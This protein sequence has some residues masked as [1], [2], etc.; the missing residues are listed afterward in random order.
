MYPSGEVKYAKEIRY[1][2]FVGLLVCCVQSG[3]ADTEDFLVNDDGSSV[4]QT[5]PR[6]AVAADG[7][8]AIVWIDKRSGSRDV[9]LQ[10][11]APDAFPVF[12]NIK[13]NDDM[14]SAYQAEPAI[15]VDLSGLYSVVWKDYRNGSYPFDSDIYFQRF[16][17]SVSQIGV[18]RNMTTEW[19]DSLKETPDI[20]LSAWGGGVLVWADY[21]NRNWDVYGQLLS[22]DGSL[23]GTNFKVNDDTGTAQQHAPRVDI[24]PEGWFVV[25]WFDNR[26][27][28]DDI[29]IQRY[30][31]L[32]NPLGSNIR[33]SSAIS[34][35]RQA[36]PDVAT[37][38]AGHFTVV[39]VDWRNGTYPAN[40]D[41]YARKFDTL[42]IPIYSDMKL[43]RDGTGR[44]QRHPTISADRRGNVAIIW[45]DSTG[46]SWDIVGQMIDVEGVVQ[47]PN[48]QANTY[49]DSAQLL[50]DV[51]L[52]GRFRYVTWVDKR[53]GQY[54][55]YASIA[56][57]NDPT[58]IPTPAMLQFEMLVG[59]ELPQSQSLEIDHAG[60][61]PL[62]YEVIVS[63]DW[64]S[65][66]PTSGITLDTVSV[67]ITTDT[68]PFGTH[69]GSLT[70][71]DND[72]N[73]SSAVVS[74]RLDVTAPI[75]ELS[76]DTVS[77]RAFAGIDEQVVGSYEITNAGAGSLAWNCNEDA[78]WLSLS[79][80]S[81][82]D[83][84]S[85]SVLANALNLVAGN[86][87]EPV[88]I[89]A[90]EVI[91]SPDTI[92][93]IL[94]VVDNLPYIVVEPDSITAVT[95]DPAAIVELLVISNEGVG[96]LNWNAIVN[97][98]WLQLDYS[99]GLDGDTITLTIDTAG[100]PPGYHTTWIDIT[101]SAS[102]NVSRRVPFILDYLQPAADTITVGFSQIEYGESDSLPVT[103]ILVDSAQQVYLP[104]QYDTALISVDSIAFASD[105][106]SY[107]TAGFTIDNLSGI[108]AIEVQSLHSDSSLPPASYEY[109]YVLF[110]AR[111]QD[112][113]S[114]IGE[115]SG[116]SMAAF[117][118][119]AGGRRLSPVVLAG[120]IQV[121]APTSV[122]DIPAGQVPGSFALCQNYPNPC[123]PST[124]IEFEMPIPA[125]VE[126]D[127]FNI[128]GQRV[129]T[130]VG[131]SLLAG[132]HQV[133][134]D[135]RLRS[136]QMAPTGIYFY[137]LRVADVSLVRKLVL[138]K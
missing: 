58:L 21:R 53:H 69:F 111:E 137:R 18:N 16:D 113:V 136:G 7:A 17:S 44:A 31:S 9:Y 121:D 133:D 64:I 57:Y 105:L 51:A 112:G 54:D 6:I 32:A 109:A 87:V 49:G 40:P 72:N 78:D 35:S 63:H 89:D 15:G 41:I 82:T 11:F 125:S 83:S 79:A 10:R 127:L 65:A 56:Q 33:I 50:A 55:I 88:E 130:L 84:A 129:R 117:V 120:E 5:S 3:W 128:L 2:V 98:P 71:V 8:F 76:L 135:G 43:N 96:I 22:S 107:V 26:Y 90:G 85:V 4:E 42:M 46:A 28:D 138:I 70:L 19:P 74:I 59:G 92:W 108:V 48:F 14:T 123:N 115:P 104:L 20:A 47:E 34:G 93:V 24:S 102:F 134:W 132:K 27:G 122:P 118:V 37:D 73:D 110:T 116:S 95:T 38:G 36:F 13:I 66:T 86:Y 100:L 119:D 61:N 99:S 12:G 77:L 23:L 81:G 114:V 62:N 103:L 91:N 106:P 45:S 60:Y 131:E 52:D 39:W 25:T 101:D 124:T 1:F 94:E 29:Y 30:D 80:Y 97:D 68:L 126:L 67:A 75:L